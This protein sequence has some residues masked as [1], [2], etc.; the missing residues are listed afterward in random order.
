LN[1]WGA[2][3]STGASAGVSA[4]PS[5]AAT[6]SCAR[7]AWQQHAG[8]VATVYRLGWCVPWL[9]HSGLLLEYSWLKV[10]PL[11]EL[12][13]GWI[14]IGSL[15]LPKTPCQD[16]VRR[17]TSTILLVCMSDGCAG[18]EAASLLGWFSSQAAK[19]KGAGKGNTY[20]ACP[21]LPHVPCPCCEQRHTVPHV[22]WL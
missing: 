18:W 9:Q 5:A 19:G 10:L 13:F 2:W 22:G 1:S 7:L 21:S 14:W 16:A 20:V 17:R 12:C 15:N 11:A 8:C 3:Q 4:A 6:S